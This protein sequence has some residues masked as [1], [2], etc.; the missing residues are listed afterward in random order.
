MAPAS[1]EEG[2]YWGREELLKVSIYTLLDP[3]DSHLEGMGT[4]MVK[5]AVILRPGVVVPLV[6]SMPL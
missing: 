5:G 4:K 1:S 3:P 6:S 2:S